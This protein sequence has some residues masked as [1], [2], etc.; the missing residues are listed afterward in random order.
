MYLPNISS[1]S[2]HSD[3]IDEDVDILIIIFVI[4]INDIA[5]FSLLKQV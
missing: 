3:L 4:L 5:V 2:C 1:D